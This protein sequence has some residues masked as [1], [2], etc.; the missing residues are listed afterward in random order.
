MP[1]TFV[2]LVLIALVATGDAIYSIRARWRSVALLRLISSLGAPLA[3]T[4]PHNARRVM[5]APA[6]LYPFAWVLR[7][8]VFFLLLNAFTS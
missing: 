1:M 4:K 2:R 8:L 3:G 5:L 6:S 7:G